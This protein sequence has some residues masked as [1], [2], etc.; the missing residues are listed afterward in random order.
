MYICYL[1]TYVY[2]LKSQT[3]L[4]FSYHAPTIKPMRNPIL[5]ELLFKTANIPRKRT[6]LTS[7]SNMYAAG[8]V[9]PQPNPLSMRPTKTGAKDN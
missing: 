7:D 9:N 4:N 2:G 5:Q 3:Y 1:I 8:R 6:R